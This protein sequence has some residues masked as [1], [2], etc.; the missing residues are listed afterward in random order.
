[1]LRVSDG[2]AIAW[3]SGVPLVT[4]ENF[5]RAQVTPVG[6]GKTWTRVAAH[7]P[8][9]SAAQCR[10]K[11]VNVL[12]PLVRRRNWDAEEDSLLAEAVGACEPGRWANVARS[13]SRK[14][15]EVANNGGGSGAS[16]GAVQATERTDDQCKKRWRVLIK[17]A[18]A[19]KEKVKAN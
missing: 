15:L 18:E 19:E 10:E 4:T 6:D 17:R 3:A 12:N 11:W 16:A 9:R 5:V 13:L 8:G 7:V 2:V 14:N 1:M